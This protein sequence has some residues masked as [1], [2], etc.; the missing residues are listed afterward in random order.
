MRFFNGKSS[1]LVEGFRVTAPNYGN[2]VRGLIIRDPWISMIL[3]GW[4]T[5][6]MRT[7]A[8]AIRGPIALIKGGSG[9][10]VGVANLV[11][12]KAPLSEGEMRSF[13]LMHGIDNDKIPQVVADGWVVPWVL[14]D[15]VAIE[16]VLYS[17][18]NDAV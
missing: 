5:W 14:E 3:E 1:Q 16:P 12:S 10:A 4:K 17:H 13:E 18:P 9:T 7:K 2:I 8:T 6:E 15:A 11:D